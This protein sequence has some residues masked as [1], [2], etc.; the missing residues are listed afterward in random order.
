MIHKLVLF[1]KYMFINFTQ[2]RLNS[3]I[4]FSTFGDKAGNLRFLHILCKN[5]LY[6]KK[7]NLIVLHKICK[8]LKLPAL[9]FE[10]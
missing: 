10:I 2:W 1:I 9:P 7:I 8:N 6:Y 4:F 3:Y 5:N